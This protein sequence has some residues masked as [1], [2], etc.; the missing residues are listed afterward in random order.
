MITQKKK[1]EIWSCRVH[2]A[3]SAAILLAAALCCLQLKKLAAEQTHG[4]LSPYV[5]YIHVK[6][7]YTRMEEYIYIYMY[8]SFSPPWT[9]SAAVLEP[10]GFCSS[11]AMAG[12]ASS[13]N[14]VNVTAA[15]RTITFVLDFGIV[16][17]NFFLDRMSTAMSMCLLITRAYY[18][19]IFRAWRP[20]PVFIEGVTWSFPWT[21]GDLGVNGPI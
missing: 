15:T 16:D 9:V 8:I 18:L 7:K 20:R 5:V 12:K 3:C 21:R 10:T 13:R 17:I 1:Y 2:W 11:E 14:A 4:S 6:F 19:S